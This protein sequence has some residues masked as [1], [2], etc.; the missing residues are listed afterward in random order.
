MII[1]SRKNAK[2][3]TYGG[4]TGMDVTGLWV[5]AGLFITGPWPWGMGR[6]GAAMPGG[7][8]SQEMDE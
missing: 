4:G 1:E 6:P 8:N 5:R 7:Y 3:V 2:E